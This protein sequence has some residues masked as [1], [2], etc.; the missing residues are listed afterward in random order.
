[1]HQTSLLQSIDLFRYKDWTSFI[2]YMVLKVGFIFLCKVRYGVSCYMVEHLMVL[3]CY[4]LLLP[5]FKISPCCSIFGENSYKCSWRYI[6]SITFSVHHHFALVSIGLHP[7]YRFVLPPH[8]CHMIMR[9]CLVVLYKSREIQGCGFFFFSCLM[10][11]PI[12]KCLVVE[13]GK[14]K[15]SSDPW[16]TWKISHCELVVRKHCA[17]LLFV[18]SIIWIIVKIY[19]DMPQHF[20]WYCVRSLF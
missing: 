14:K 10:L 18:T 1:M 3:L 7:T 5:L 13:W 11:F 6:L 9:N 8:Q 19:H 15:I 20:V 12:K 2:R 17:E 4:W 16:Q